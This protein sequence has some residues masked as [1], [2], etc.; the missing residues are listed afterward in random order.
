MLSCSLF[1]Y[2]YKAIHCYL[3]FKKK[4]D[5]LEKN[6]LSPVFT[7]MNSDSSSNKNTYNIT[8]KTPNYRRSG[9]IKN[10]ESNANAN[11]LNLEQMTNTMNTNRKKSLPKLKE[12]SKEITMKESSVDKHVRRVFYSN[13]RRDKIMEKKEFREYIKEKENIDKK[14][15]PKDVS[16]DKDKR[17]TSRSKYEKLIKKDLTIEEKNSILQKMHNYHQE[18]EIYIAK[19]T[20]EMS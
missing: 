7:N 2:S 15:I 16:K 1:F 6:L 9:N 18:Q 12:Q 20:T 11:L 5:S 17:S 3:F 4:K 8:S 19:K 13:E 10:Q 14:L